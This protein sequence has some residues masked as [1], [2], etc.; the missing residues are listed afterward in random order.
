[1]SQWVDIDTL[2][3]LVESAR[4]IPVAPA[5]VIL[6]F[7]LAGL[8]AFPFSLL[9]VVTVITYGP[10]PGFIYSLT[11][12]TLSAVVVYWIGDRLGHNLVRKL[13]GGKINRISRKIA[14]HGI[15]NIIFV[16]IV[17]VAPFTLI[18]LVAGASHINFRDYTLGTLLGFIPGMLAMT[19]LADRIEAIV[20]EPDPGNMIWLTVTAMV[21][22]ATAYSLIKW[23]KG[24]SEKSPLDD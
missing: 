7:I 1:L 18:N 15:I 24:E 22:A 6:G 17:P 21:V 4:D 13:G 8:V 16:R 19:L 9:I 14:R 3:G 23:L 2:S 11:G 12:G 10:V 20:Q 5:W